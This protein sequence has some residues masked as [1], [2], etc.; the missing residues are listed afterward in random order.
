FVSFFPEPCRGQTL[1]DVLHTLRRFVEAVRARHPDHPPV[2]Y[3]NC[4]AGWAV[5]L[6]SADCHGLVGP[7]VLNGSPLSYWS[8]E[9]GI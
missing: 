3:G 8:G 4:Q 6:L 5:T 7:A 9:A 1:A 2:L